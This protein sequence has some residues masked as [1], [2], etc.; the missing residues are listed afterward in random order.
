MTGEPKSASIKTKV[1]IGFGLIIC[2]VLFV[3]FIAYKS[4]NLLVSS[5]DQISQPD[6]KVIL[7]NKIVRDI[8]EAEII[9]RESTLRSDVA[10]LEPFFV[11]TDSVNNRLDSLRVLSK[12]E[13]ETMVMLDSI[14]FLIN[15]K[16]QGADG[17]VKLYSRQKSTDYYKKAIKEI[18]AKEIAAPE[19]DTILLGDQGPINI[20]SAVLVL[21]S[22]T[23]LRVEKEKKG[24]LRSKKRKR[25]DSI[26]RAEEQA[27]AREQ[28]ESVLDEI[29]KSKEKEVA[30]VP[31][32]SAVVTDT[33]TKI[34][35]DI[36]REEQQSEYA[37]TLK[38]LEIIDNNSLILNQ[39][40]FLI[41]EMEAVEANEHRQNIIK[42]R[43]TSNNAIM[44]IIGTGILG[45][46]SGIMFIYIIFNDI[47][48][49][50]YYRRLLVK[51]REKA[52]K[53][54]KAKEDFLANMS[55]EIR[56][57]LN[58][59]L[60][61][62]EQ[63]SNT[64]LEKT[65]NDYLQAITSSSSHL[66]ATVNDVLD[67]SKIQANKLSIEE[68]PFK[69]INVVKDVYATLILKAEQKNIKLK[70]SFDEKLNQVLAGDPFR[71]KQ[72]LLNLANNGIKF[73]DKGYVEIKAILEKEFKTKLIARIEVNDTGIGI[74]EENIHKIFEGFS[75]SDSSTTRK[76]GGTGLGLSI[77]KKLVELQHGTL[78]VKSEVNKGSSFVVEL[79]FKKA[80]DFKPLPQENTLPFSDQI[81]DDYKVLVVDDDKLNLQL[82]EIIFK[83]WGLK[84][85]FVMNGKEATEKL[86][87]DYYHLIIT[88][89]QMPEFS[90][91][92]L[93]KHVRALSDPKK[94]QTA[95]LAFTAN[96]MKDDIQK[97]L[98]SG[99]NDYLLKPFKEAHLFNK[100]VSA[101]KIDVKGDPKSNGHL[102]RAPK[103][104]VTKAPDP[105]YNLDEILQFTGERNE[106]LLEVLESFL[107]NTKNSLLMMDSGVKNKDWQKVSMMAHKML[108]SFQHLQVSSMIPILKKLESING[109]SQSS[110]IGP[111]VQKVETG[112]K[113][114]M[115]ALKK[116]IISLKQELSAKQLP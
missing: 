116:E 94:S 96:V 42:A 95:I 84:S 35:A 68:I 39:V 93:A 12:N 61:F 1:M 58:A 14:T 89:I 111:L 60:G 34:I 19:S 101:L 7:L 30:V 92:D 17:Y 86:E 67:F 87:Q 37:I 100:I 25:E 114:V 44:I 47:T 71:L 15:E 62:S 55:H 107:Y 50:N 5:I 66:L 90:G 26:K 65:Q 97:Y 70:Y 18:T 48:K 83:K 20:D 43:E 115:K 24:F 16:L 106:S 81:F 108:P 46:F 113:E 6:T 8:A 112:A 38:E 76:Y 23:N 2:G 64:S 21:D 53:E 82:T 4:F 74:A 109:H 63:L 69:L 110:E 75:Q 102:E 59:I 32:Q 36:K 99:I 105:L 10:G 41:N 33:V 52:I 98:D 51:A 54:G 104:P 22:I 56:T 72:I 31:V 45:T 49:R 91:I 103:Q 28:I 9:L 29:N 3:G 11:Y 73:T 77:S 80:K 57:P 13:P 78:E 40:K 79:T 88:D 85:D 27:K